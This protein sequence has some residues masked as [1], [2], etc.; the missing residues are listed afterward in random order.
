MTSADE[1]LRHEIESRVSFC[2]CHNCREE[3]FNQLTDADVMATLG[4]AL[5]ELT[6]RGYDMRNMNN[7]KPEKVFERQ[8]AH[9][10]ERNGM[11]Q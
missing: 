9:F 11:M 5:E 8:L 2:L 4:W 10:Y 3:Q 1:K 6:E 7:D